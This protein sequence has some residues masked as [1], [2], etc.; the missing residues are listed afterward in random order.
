MVSRVSSES[1]ACLCLRYL[2]F[3]IELLRWFSARAAWKTVKTHIEGW[4][5]ELC[6]HPASK[7]L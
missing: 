1:V 5:P 7:L 3:A 6:T 2:M 4:F